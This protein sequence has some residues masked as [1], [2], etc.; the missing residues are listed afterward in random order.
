MGGADFIVDGPVGLQASGALVEF[1]PVQETDAVDD[2]MAMQVVGVDV[3]GYQY[4]EVG[5][6]PLGQFQSDGVGLLGRQVIRL[7][8]GLD[9]VV[10][11][12]PVRFPI[13]LLGELHFRESRL[14][15]AV[16]AGHQPL[17]LPQR[18]FLLADIASDTAER[19]P[20]SA[21]V[22]NGGEGSHLVDTSSISFAS[23]LID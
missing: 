4:L 8:K 10:V 17:S 12:P 14:G 20:A 2:Q 9:E 16:P 23:S 21:P 1:F 6:L 18:L 7:C 3:G 19:T 15:G 5:E 11:L 22:L 13:P